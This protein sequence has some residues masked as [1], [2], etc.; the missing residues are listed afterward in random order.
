MRLFSTMRSVPFAIALA[1]ILV[2]VGF[3]LLQPS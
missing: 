1:V 2:L 3:W